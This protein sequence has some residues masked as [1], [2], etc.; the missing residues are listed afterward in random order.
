MSSASFTKSSLSVINNAPV[1]LFIPR[2]LPNIS[3]QFICEYFKTKK[4]GIVTDIN[5]KHRV[6]ENHNKYWFAFVNVQFFDTSYG[7]NMYQNIVEKEKTEYMFYNELEDK[8][9]EISVRAQDRKYKNKSSTKEKEEKEVKTEVKK[10]IKKEVKK[11]IK[12]EV[13]LEEGEIIEDTHFTIYDHVEMYHDYRELEKEIYGN[14]A[15]SWS[16]SSSPMPSWGTFIPL[17]I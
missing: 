8:Y 2:L 11:E 16:S 10:E 14:N 3:K 1:V 15:F 12:K 7:K 4:I 5:A 6:N 13:E 9:W 17:R